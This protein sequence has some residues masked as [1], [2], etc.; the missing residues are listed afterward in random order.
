M[1]EPSDKGR[2][3]YDDVINILIASY[4]SLFEEYRK[5]GK[6][7]K[8]G[9]TGYVYEKAKIHKFITSLPNSPP[10]KFSTS[11]NIHVYKL[12]TKVKVAK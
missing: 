4:P 8:S 5:Y 3:E 7:P 10:I 11:A 9:E 6:K 12:K 2:I 1:F